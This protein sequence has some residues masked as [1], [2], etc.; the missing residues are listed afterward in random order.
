[1]TFTCLNL[2][3]IEKCNPDN[4]VRNLFGRICMSSSPSDCINYGIYTL[5]IKRLTLVLDFFYISIA[6]IIE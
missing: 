5:V 2:S 4:T 3:A 6:E 1:M